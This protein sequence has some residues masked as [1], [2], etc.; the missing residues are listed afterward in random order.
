MKYARQDAINT[1]SLA[2]ESI[3]SQAAAAVFESRL[4]GIVA[5]REVTGPD[6]AIQAIKKEAALLL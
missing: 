4:L 3:D 6:K 2:G 1:I 5:Q